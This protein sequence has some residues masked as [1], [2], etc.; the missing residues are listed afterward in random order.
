MWRPLVTPNTAL[1]CRSRSS[2]ACSTHP[3][4]TVDAKPNER[5][6]ERHRKRARREWDHRVNRAAASRAIAGPPWWHTCRLNEPPTNSVLLSRAG[7]FVFSVVRGGDQSLWWRMHGCASGTYDQLSEPAPVV[8]LVR[9]RRSLLL[10]LL[11]LGLSFSSS[12]RASHHF[13]ASVSNPT[14]P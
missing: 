14:I 1:S 2:P 12:D 10:L 6:S 7:V 8:I 4:Q 5:A 11:A 3:L 9:A 13:H